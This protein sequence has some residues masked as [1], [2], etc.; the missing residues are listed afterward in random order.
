MQFSPLIPSVLCWVYP[1]MWLMVSRGGW[2]VKKNRPPKKSNAH[3]YCG[4]SHANFLF[5][6]QL[7]DQRCW[8]IY[9]ISLTGSLLGD[10]SNLISVFGSF[11]LLD[12]F[13]SLSVIACGLKN[14]P[15]AY[16]QSHFPMIPFAALHNTCV[17]VSAERLLF[18][19]QG[20]KFNVWTTRHW[21]E[22]V[23]R[24]KMSFQ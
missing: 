12:E 16:T 11:F 1:A 13:L 17:G 19:T 6:H 18:G 2:W 9:R 20:K 15:H 21:N 5:L 22:N 23:L 10:D 7:N 24:R 8:N 14:L 4:A 3:G